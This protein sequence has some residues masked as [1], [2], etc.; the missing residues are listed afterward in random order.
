MQDKSNEVEEVHPTRH[1]THSD[2]EILQITNTNDNMPK[3]SLHVAKNGL[4]MR[5]SVGEWRGI[6]TNLEV[7]SQ[8]RA[9]AEKQ[10]ELS[11]WEEAHG[12]ASAIFVNICIT[13]YHVSRSPGL[14]HI[15][16]QSL[17]QDSQMWIST[18]AVYSTLNLLV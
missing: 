8:A 10:K 2:K 6:F 13:Q 11:Q 17:E 18:N 5:I 3:N 16:W 14:L 12:R 9:R 4:Y 1:H 7:L 15:K